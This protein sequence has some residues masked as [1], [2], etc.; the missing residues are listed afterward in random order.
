MKRSI[1]KC[2]FAFFAMFFVATASASN[3]SNK[4]L[5]Q[6]QKAVLLMDQ[7]KY[8]EALPL[9]K[10]L[11]RE[12]KNFVDASWSLAE[13]Y[14][15]MGDDAKHIQALQYVAKP[16]V[17]RY[18]NSMMRLGNAL[19][20]LCNYQEA[21]DIYKQIPPSEQYYYKTAQPKIAKAEA[22]LKL[23]ANP[24]PFQVTNM[25]PNINTVYDDYWP[26]LTAD[27]SLFSITV[28]LNRLE[29]QSDFGKSVHEDIFVSKKQPD[30]H[31]GKIVNAGTN[32]NT[33]YNEGAQS[34]SLDGRYM[35]FVACER[36]GGQGGCDIYYSIRE[37]DKWGPAINPGAPL[38]T[39]AW[40][41]GPSLSPTGDKLYFASNRPGG[42][43]N[44]D[45]WVVDLTIAQD[46][47]LTF[48]NPRNLGPN[49]NTKD[50]EMSPFIHADN[51][52][53]FFSSRGR[54][55]LGNY[56]VFVT[57]LDSTGKWGTSQNIGYPLN[58]CKDEIGFVVNAYGD[59]AYFTSNGQEKNGR[60]KDIYELKL[61]DGNF[62]PMKHMKYAKGKIVD[63]DTKKP[64]M[65]QIDVYSIKSNKKV[66]KSVSD[67]AT[68]EFVSC[69]PEGEDAGVN[70]DRK[71]YLFYSE[72]FDEN[73]K[74]KFPEQGV[75]MEKIEVGKKITLKN[76]FFDFDKYSLKPASHHELD[77]L[78]KF[79]KDN[80]QV[81][82]RLCGHTDS[83]GN[84]DY[85]VTLSE[86]RAKIAY[87]YLV[88]RRIAKERLEYK[89][90]GPD[91]PIATNATAEGRAL[92]R[93]TEVIIIAK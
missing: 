42:I 91:Q 64:V 54:G 35:F 63:A 53:L 58:T 43:G 93:R 7:G 25:G 92:N 55:G 87:Q 86:N 9:F 89:G 1:S 82:I 13:L 37:G 33:S 52:T 31:W 56:D 2:I 70:V 65:A 41:T 88:D 85:N 10:Q 76:I 21:I 44:S 79:L 57:Y 66:F 45:I 22:A 34:V 72:Y 90:F 46:G 26:S 11:V 84:H 16:K 74:V 19:L 39:R 62:K 59:K 47:K 5:L 60:G 24:V 83:K 77:R 3:I 15:R 69:V 61:Q 38:N 75:K 27:E 32:I 50:D 49:I 6:Y 23:V 20:D 8:K 78:V 68:G 29:G 71:G 81:R 14:K 4:E 36:Q 12:N 17:D 73:K 51:S 48:S 30:G 18:W 40:E 80:P 67:G 28:K